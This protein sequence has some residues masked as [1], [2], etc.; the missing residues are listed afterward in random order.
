MGTD[1]MHYDRLVDGALRGVVVA[2]LRRAIEEGLPGDHHFYISFRTDYP[3]VR[4]GNDLRA[5][6]PEELTIVLQHQFWDLTVDDEAIGVA[7]SF[8][9]RRQHL[10]IPLEAITAFADPSVKFGLQFKTTGAEAEAGD[11]PEADAPGEPDAAIVGATAEDADADAGDHGEDE[12]AKV[13]TLD[14]F[15]KK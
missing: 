3:G 13:V 15:R 6:Y 2:A 11:G 5:R 7:L 1:L 14:A 8:G 12:A 9:G 4:L 10:V